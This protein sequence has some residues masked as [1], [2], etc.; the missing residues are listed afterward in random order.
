MR[1]K[2]NKLLYVLRGFDENG[3]EMDCKE[4]GFKNSFRSE[5]IANKFV[6]FYK[7]LY[8]KFRFEI[9]KINN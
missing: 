3:N 8:P 1:F 6:D 4:F 9:D 7:V 2:S 5:K